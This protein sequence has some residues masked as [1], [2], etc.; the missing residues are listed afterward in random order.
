[1]TSDSNQF[2]PN[3]QRFKRIESKLRLLVILAIVQTVVIG[4]LIGCL[5]LKQFMPSTLTL[6]LAIVGLGVFAYLFRRQIP[7]WF[8]NASRLFFSQM[9]AAQKS[10]SLKPE[11]AKD[12][13]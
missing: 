13:S 12:I 11:Q 1:M 7:A 9:F 5:L 4:L 2:D 3:E 6:I 8:G 10:E